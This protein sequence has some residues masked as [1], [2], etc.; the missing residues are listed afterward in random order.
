MQSTARV[1]VF[2]INPPNS[3][4]L[5]ADDV[6]DA[7]DIVVSK[8]I[9][10]TDWASFP[11]LGI[12][13]L[14][15]YVDALPDF[16]S[17]YVDGV[18][19]PLDSIL[20]AIRERADRTLAVCLS[21]ITAN[22]EASIRI[23]RAVRSLDSHIA[24]VVGNDHF[25][26]LNREILDRHGELIDCGFVGNEVYCGLV[27]F[28]RDRQRS[29]TT[30]VYPGSIRLEA[31][32]IVA[33]PAIREPVNRIID[34]DLIDRTLPHTTVYTSNFTRRLGRRILAL[35]G[36]QVHKGVPVEI[37]RGCINSAATMPVHSAPFSTAGCGKTNFQPITRGP[38]CAAHGKRATTTCT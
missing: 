15:S 36:R 3:N 31:G 37:G 32:R 1:V 13:S 20:A 18:I 30:G 10:H 17:V 12:L 38:P 11:H 4:D 19:H 9:Q 22:Y 21:A 27:D 14:A 25:T 23:A 5:D 29:R 28:L 6:V 16:E 2:F 34:Y 35:T 26:A 24:I 7:N 33:D 8:G